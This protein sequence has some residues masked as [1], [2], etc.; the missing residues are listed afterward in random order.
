MSEG[1]RLAIFRFC[2]PAVVTGGA[3]E[4][5]LG[6]VNPGHDRLDIA[7]GVAGWAV[8]VGEKRVDAAL[9]NSHLLA[10]RPLGTTHCGSE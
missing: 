6:S 4:L 5:P 7:L 8:T 1:L 9:M 3:P 2:Q 10:A